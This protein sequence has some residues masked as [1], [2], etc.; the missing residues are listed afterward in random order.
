MIPSLFLRYVWQD[1]CQALDGGG[2]ERAKEQ[3]NGR[4]RLMGEAATEWEMA[5]RMDMGG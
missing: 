3:A 5:V 1:S 4:G 2:A